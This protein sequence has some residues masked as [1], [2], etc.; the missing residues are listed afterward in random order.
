RF[1]AQYP[2]KY[3]VILGDSLFSDKYS[4]DS[5]LQSPERKLQD[6]SSVSRDWL[7]LLC[8]CAVTCT[9]NR[10]RKGVKN[11]L[12]PLKTPIFCSLSLANDQTL[13]E[14]SWPIY[15]LN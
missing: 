4:S 2:H 10:R 14:N 7:I 15:N 5:G 6:V 13:R 12:H 1:I 3:R 11:R 9:F 8:G